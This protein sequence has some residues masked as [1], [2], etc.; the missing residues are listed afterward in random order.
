MHVYIVFNSV[1][2]MFTVSNGLPRIKV[3]Q[4]CTRVCMH[5][6]RYSRVVATKSSKK[7]PCFRETLIVSLMFCIRVYCSF[8]ILHSI[9]C[10]LIFS[11]VKNTLLV[12]V[13][14]FIT[15]SLSL[16]IPVSQFHLSSFPH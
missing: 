1:Q 12:Y 14:G 7:L 10:T 2:N 15:S 13:P 4:L 3:K 9:Y 8:N 6:F 16:F 5:K 11:Y